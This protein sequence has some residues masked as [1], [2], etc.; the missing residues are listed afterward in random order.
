MEIIIGTRYLSKVYNGEIHALDDVNIEIRRSEF[1]WLVGPSGAGKTTF[2]RILYADKKPSSGIVM[3]VGMDVTSIKSSHIP[4]LRRQMGIIFQD[5]KLL[6]NKTVFENV[7]LAPWALGYSR[8]EVYYRTLKALNTV[9]LTHKKSAFPHELSGGEQQKVAIARAIAN[10]PPLVLADEPTGNLDTESALA[11]I[12]IFSNL[13]KEGVTIIVTTHNLTLSR[14]AGTRRIFLDHG[15]VV[16]ED[17][18]LRS[19]PVSP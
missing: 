5:F 3:V 15:M 4:R 6:Y 17:Y 2:L 9:E 12:E 13:A 16:D 7:A 1:V 18:P 8:R 14:R 19:E 11:I 10:K